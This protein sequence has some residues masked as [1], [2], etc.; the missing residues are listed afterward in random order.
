MVGDRRKMSS[1]FFTILH[2]PKTKEVIGS[3]DLTCARN[4]FK[5][6]QL[7]YLIPGAQ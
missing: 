6:N 3:A 1:K 7:G 2:E 5:K 4:L